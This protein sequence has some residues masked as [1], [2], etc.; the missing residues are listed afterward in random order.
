MDLGFVLPHPGFSLTVIFLEVQP[1]FPSFSF[2][3]QFSHPKDGGRGLGH[4]Q[5]KTK[6]TKASK[7]FF[8]GR[9]AWDAR[10][11]GTQLLAS[12]G[13]SHNW[14]DLMG[15]RGRQCPQCLDPKQDL[16][17]QGSV[18]FGRSR[19]QAWVPT[20][21]NRWLWGSAPALP[22]GGFQVCGQQH[23]SICLC[24]FPG[25]AEPC[26]DTLPPA[27][28]GS[29][30]SSHN[31]PF[32]FSVCLVHQLS[33][34]YLNAPCSHLPSQ[35]FL[36]RRSVAEVPPCTPTAG[37]RIHP[38]VS[39]CL[40]ATFFMKTCRSIQLKGFWPPLTIF[41]CTNVICAQVSAPAESP[42]CARAHDR[43]SAAEGQ[44]VLHTLYSLSFSYVLAS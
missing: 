4:P 14:G 22:D 25:Q 24:S 7:R 5:N 28:P 8:H 29:S 20:A 33:G 19:K 41:S 10:V 21:G 12:E 40:N 15:G 11:G 44:V 35:A 23:S 1:G 17:R 18:S 34:C 3:P 6:E 43:H 30:S 42:E 38:A 16:P 9:A 37:G 36:V 2:H 26:W 27:A 39:V 31:S 13:Y 32:W